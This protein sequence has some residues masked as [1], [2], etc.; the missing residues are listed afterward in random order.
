[1]FHTSLDARQEPLPVL[2]L[3]AKR[4][5]KTL[6]PDSAGARKLA[7]RFGADLV[8]VRHRVDLTGERRYTTVELLVEVREIR[9][10]SCPDAE[11]AL[12]LGF[13]ERTLRAT[14]Q[15][16]GARWDPASRL[17]YLPAQQV[18][19]LGLEARIVKCAAQ[20]SG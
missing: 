8:C 14:L 13:G 18:R 6:A 7:R 20:K 4:V 2:S 10:R 15:A 16:A 11:V 5:I 3:R 19:A 12:R 17:W 1:M 9:G